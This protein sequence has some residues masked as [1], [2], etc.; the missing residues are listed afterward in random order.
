MRYG[1]AQKTLDLS[2]APQ[3]YKD[4]DEFIAAEQDLVEV[5]V[6]RHA[7]SSCINGKN[8]LYYILQ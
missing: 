7:A 5:Q 2:E 4:I 3:A 6:R 8:V 1:K